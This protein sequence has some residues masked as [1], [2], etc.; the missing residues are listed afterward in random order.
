MA[1]EH[2]Q[3][4]EEELASELHRLTEYIL[5]ER[6]SFHKVQ[7]L[8][9]HRDFLFKEPKFITLKTDYLYVTMKRMQEILKQ[10]GESS[11]TLEDLKSFNDMVKKCHIID[12]DQLPEREHLEIHPG[13]WQ[14]PKRVH[15]KFEWDPERVGLYQS[16]TLKQQRFMPYKIRGPE[17]EKELVD[18]QV[19]GANLLDYLMAYPHLIPETWKNK[20]IYFLGTRFTV[21]GFDGNGHTSVSFLFYNEGRDEWSRGEKNLQSDF[22]DNGYVAYYLDKKAWSLF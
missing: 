6:V 9:E 15:G 22:Y 1:Q 8:I 2:C 11:L 19:F 5:K 13:V 20:Y 3:T 10:L 17:L 7:A 16:K 4:R 21:C 12:F 18:V 14:L